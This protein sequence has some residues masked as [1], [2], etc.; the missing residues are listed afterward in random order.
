MIGN[1]R[2]PVPWHVRLTAARR[3]ILVIVAGIV[4]FALEPGSLRLSNRVLV[5]WDMGAVGYLLLSWLTI[6]RADVAMTHFRARMYD[7]SGYVIFLLVLTAACVSMVAI[8]FLI[9]D[10]RGLAPR[11][12]LA[13]LTLSII[14]LMAAW[15]LIHTVFAFHYAREYYAPDDDGTP[16]SGGLRFPECDTP[17]YLDFAYYAFVIGMTSQVSDVAVISSDM[18][19]TTLA[20]GMLSFVFNIAVLALSINVI[21]GAL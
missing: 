20:H 15:M 21:S 4:V 1:M 7:Q 11:A 12:K 9:G 2:L 17:T 18:R 3:L 6:L 10:I 16:T 13:H 5:A 8:A 19:R 14:A